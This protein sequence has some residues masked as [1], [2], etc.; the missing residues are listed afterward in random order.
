MKTVYSSE[1]S[2]A[3][4]EQLETN[5][6]EIARLQKERAEFTDRRENATFLKK[7]GGFFTGTEAKIDEHINSL[8]HINKSVSE[9]IEQRD[10]LTP[11]ELA[12]QDVFEHLDKLGTKMWAS[13]TVQDK[14]GQFFATRYE[15]LPTWE[16][17]NPNLPGKSG[18]AMVDFES[19][20]DSPLANFSSKR[21]HFTAVNPPRSKGIHEPGNLD[22][23]GLVL[24]THEGDSQ[25]AIDESFFEDG[26][27]E[28]LENIVEIAKV[29]SDKPTGHSQNVPYKVSYDTRL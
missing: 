23:I 21:L 16:R 24:N 13:R 3:Q 19:A 27:S 11:V 28:D 14:K 8:N 4:S 10:K 25:L 29:I 18:T 17:V 26:S 9:K 5:K 12:K 1:I 6:S 2:K 15:H 22:K 20:P 7:I